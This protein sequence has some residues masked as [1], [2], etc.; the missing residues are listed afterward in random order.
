MS[1]PSERLNEPRGVRNIKK[2][3]VECESSKD[4]FTDLLATRTAA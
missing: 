1:E 4:F 2:H 3:H